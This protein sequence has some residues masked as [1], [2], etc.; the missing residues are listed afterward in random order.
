[1]IRFRE[2]DFE[3]LEHCEGLS[4]AW[5]VRYSDLEPSYSEAECL[6]GVHA[7]GNGGA[8]RL[9]RARCIRSAGRG[10]IDDAQSLF[11]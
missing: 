1:M 6:F 10:R 11:R 3:H 9:A 4:P 2:R 8:T 5:P 7:K